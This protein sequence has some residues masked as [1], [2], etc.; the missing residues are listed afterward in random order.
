MKCF[1]CLLYASNYLSFELDYANRSRV[2][3]SNTCI[4]TTTLFISTRAIYPAAAV[5]SV[6]S[7]RCGDIADSDEPIDNNRLLIFYLLLL[8]G[9]NA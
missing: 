6:F 1:V 8:T 5:G 9:N 4:Q 7:Q 2:I 3:Y